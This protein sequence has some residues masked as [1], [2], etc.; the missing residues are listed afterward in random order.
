MNDFH[1]II[2]KISTNERIYDIPITELSYNQGK[3]IYEFAKKTQPWLE[4]N[5]GEFGKDWFVEIDREYDSLRLKFND[6][7]SETFFKLAFMG[8]PEHREES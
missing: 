7:Q 3:L 1:E 6:I 4:E 8:R 5:I 2:K